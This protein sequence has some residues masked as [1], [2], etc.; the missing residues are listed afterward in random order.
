MRQNSFDIEHLERR[1]EFETVSYL[2]CFLA[3][4][5]ENEVLLRRL[6]MLRDGLLF[7]VASSTFNC[8]MI[9]QRYK[10]F[11]STARVKCI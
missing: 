2:W 11:F 1:A 6:E 3:L 4:N 10:P 9:R 5:G 7:S 8:S